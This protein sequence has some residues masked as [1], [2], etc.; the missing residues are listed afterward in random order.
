[1][2]STKLHTSMCQ[3]HWELG[4]PPLPLHSPHQIINSITAP[5]IPAR[6]GRTHRQLKLI[7]F[8]CTMP[9]RTMKT[10]RQQRETNLFTADLSLQFFTC[11][12]LFLKGCDSADSLRAKIAQLH[13]VLH[14]C[15][16]QSLLVQFL[17]QQISPLKSIL[18]NKITPQIS[19][20]I[21]SF[22]S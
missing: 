9:D 2:L 11:G 3:L 6:Q 21:Y 7:P 19:N 8:L 4:E 20:F 12:T 16:S 1:M 17:S 13:I 14:C 15:M 18:K 22:V 5:A 10:Q